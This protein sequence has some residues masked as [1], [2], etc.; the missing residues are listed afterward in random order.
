MFPGIVT[1][2]EGES[3]RFPDVSL[4]AQN[5]PPRLMLF[6]TNGLL[7]APPF[8]AFHTTWTLETVIASCGFVIV[9][10]ITLLTITIEPVVMLSHPGFGVEVT[11]GVNVRVGVNVSVGVEVTVGV[12]VAVGI[13]DGV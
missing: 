6:K 7:P 11:V 12:E 13:R 5:T 3:V 10:L 9:R 4:P 2:V 1:V 8:T